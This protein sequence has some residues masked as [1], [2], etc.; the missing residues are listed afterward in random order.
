MNKCVEIIPKIDMYILIGA[1]FL[2]GWLIR[3]EFQPWIAKYITKQKD[4]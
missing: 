2:V 1:G 3:G 4:N